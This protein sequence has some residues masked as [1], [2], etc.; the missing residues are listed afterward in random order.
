MKVVSRNQLECLITI[1]DITV[2]YTV[3]YDVNLASGGDRL[4]TADNLRWVTL[5]N[6]IILCL[7]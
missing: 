1:P 4:K 3:R 5:T 6:T 7:V 2:R